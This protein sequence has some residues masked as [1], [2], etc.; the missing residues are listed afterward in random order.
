M[1]LRILT[2]G[3]AKIA[4]FEKD[5]RT[6]SGAVLSCVTLKFKYYHAADPLNQVFC[7]L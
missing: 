7:L 5:N 4:A 2:P 3:A 1:R 6:D